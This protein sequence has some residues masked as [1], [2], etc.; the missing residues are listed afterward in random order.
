MEKK[1]ILIIMLCAVAIIAASL[2]TYFTQFAG[3]SV[4]TILHE[5]IGTVM[6]EETSKL[7]NHNGKVVLWKIDYSV[8]PELRHQVEAFK[9]AL[10][11]AGSVKIDKIR[12]FETEGKAKYRAGGGLSAQRFVRTAKKDGYADAI[13]SFI[14]APDLTEAQLKELGKPPKFVAE[15]RSPEKLKPVFAQKIVDVAIVSRFEFPAPG[16]KKPKTPREWFDN[17]FQIVTPANA[18]SLP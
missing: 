14:G 5:G 11:R 9:K 16:T 15:V 4:E 1:R 7:I 17:R 10:S 12:D 18:A 8:A 13:V 3:P 2:F 6:A